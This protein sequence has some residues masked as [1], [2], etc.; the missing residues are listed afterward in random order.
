ML[1]AWR[2][3]QVMS[4]VQFNNLLFNQSQISNFTSSANNARRPLDSSQ[5]FLAAHTP[6]NHMQ[7]LGINSTDLCDLNPRTWT[8]ILVYTLNQLLALLLVTSSHATSVAIFNSLRMAREEASRLS[9][10]LLLCGD[11]KVHCMTEHAVLLAL[12][13]VCLGSLPRFDNCAK[14]HRRGHNTSHLIG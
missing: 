11:R 4:I 12:V 6:C 2:S 1:P 5:R 10:F 14:I 8:S 9:T 3:L 7:S 13:D